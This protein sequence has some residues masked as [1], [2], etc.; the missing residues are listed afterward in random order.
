M[1]STSDR[2]QQPD[3]PHTQSGSQSAHAPPADCPDT[4]D[5]DVLDNLIYSFYFN[6]SYN[7]IILN[8]LPLM[9]FLFY[10]WT[11]ES[12]ENTRAHSSMG[13]MEPT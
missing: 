13:R 12:E 4:D 2:S 10:R 9:D 5:V 7:L 11:G 1:G 8:H 3:E 6:S